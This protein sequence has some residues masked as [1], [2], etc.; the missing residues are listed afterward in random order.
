MRRHVELRA[1]RAGVHS[2]YDEQ[3]RKYASRYGFDWRLI[4]AQMY[5]ESRF[6]P[7]A[8]S[9]A[10]ALGLMQVLP[11]TARQFGFSNLTNPEDGVH[12]GVRYL[13]WVRDRFDP[14]LPVDERNWLALAAYNAGW[15][16]VADARRLARARGWDPDRWFGHLE[17][18]MLL[19]SRPEIARGTRFGYCRCSEPV[20]YVREIRNRYH[21]YVGIDVGDR[22]ATAGS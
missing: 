3:A 7:E 6:D 8:R 21:A 16:H 14:R 20:R 15:G 11:R 10:G 22:V 13:A 2:P 12:A 4:V 1:E 5:Q 18:A 9:F 17:R 19:L